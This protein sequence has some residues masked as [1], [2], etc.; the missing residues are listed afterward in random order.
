MGVS[1]SVDSPRPSGRRRRRVPLFA[2]FNALVVAAALFLIAYPIG[3]M[4]VRSLSD[5]HGWRHLLSQPWFGAMVRDTGIVVVTSALTAVGLATL[6]VW[7]NERT[8]AG[9]GALGDVLPL[10]PLF[11]PT[12]S[13]AIGW[14]MLANPDVGF[15]NTL[16]ERVLEPLGLEYTLDIYSYPGL[17]FVY[18]LIALPFAYLPILAGFRNL[19]PTL[20]DAALVSG[21]NPRTVFTTVS[22]RA[23]GP[24]LFAGLVLTLVVTLSLFSAPV[25]LATRPGYEILAVRI[26][27]SVRGSYPP[28]YDQAAMLSVLLFAV[29]FGLWLLQRRL[30][31]SG[32]FAKVGNRGAGAHITSLGRWR[33]PARSAF[34]LYILFSAV[35]PVFALLLVSFQNFWSGDPFAT[36]WSLRHYET[37]LGTATG[38]NAVRNSLF[39]GLVTGG[40]TVLV[41]GIL[42]IFAH[43]ARGWR[44]GITNGV[45]K[46]PAA[47]TNT[48]FGV[49]FVIA[50][51]GPP[52]NWGGTTMILAVAYFVVF[53]PYAA[54][55]S[56]VSV[57][58]IDASLEEASAVSGAREGTTV[59]RVVIPLMLPGLLA[60]WALVFV[61][62]IGDLSLA[63]LLGTGRTAVIGYLLLDVFEQ[64]TFGSV[65]ALSLLMTLISVPIV[66]LMLWLGVPRWKR[67]T[68]RRKKRQTAPAEATPASAD[69]R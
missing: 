32:N 7:I 30:F 52:F 16:I 64:G 36:G 22:M 8:D 54:I 15:L 62:V 18:T 55:A 69:N 41:A 29:L 50:F 34:L 19:D 26:V 37:V 61:R 67:R 65:A 42:M 44:S 40:I 46:I 2:S 10:V 49:G 12:V 4:L 48:V 28:L 51:G 43:R 11:L 14:V 23:I 53:I 58:Q 33:W 21:A 38:E 9:V 27:Y 68:K 60:A 17:I 25:I 45:A 56:E 24:S 47:I 1:V 13:T 5:S 31:A 39:H 57:S 35:L 63:V 66:L 6:L 3:I 20:E 59:R